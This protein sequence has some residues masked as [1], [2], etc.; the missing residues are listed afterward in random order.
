MSYGFDIITL[1]QSMW[2]KTRFVARGHTTQ[3]PSHVVPS[4]SVHIVLLVAALNDIYLKAT[5]IC[6]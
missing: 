5:K 3:T 1:D 6:G 4:D 2:R